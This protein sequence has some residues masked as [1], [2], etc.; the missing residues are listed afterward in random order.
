MSIKAS[1]PCQVRE[2]LPWDPDPP[3]SVREETPY[4]KLHKL[5]IRRESWQRGI[6]HICTRCNADW[7]LD[8]ASGFLLRIPAGCLDKARSWDAGMEKPAKVLAELLLNIGSVGFAAF[9]RRMKW[10]MFPCCVRDHAGVWHEKAFVILSASMPLPEWQK[11]ESALSDAAHVE[12]SRFA[13]PL[14]IRRE[15][16]NAMEIA[17]GF[18]PTSIRTSSGRCFNLWPNTDFMDKDGI[19]GSEC[20]LATDVDPFRLKLLT[21]SELGPRPWRRNV[22]RVDYPTFHGELTEDF[23]DLL[24]S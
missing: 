7:Y 5:I 1:C 4:F 8:H 11:G 13:L 14:D 10:L 6:L 2:S 16:Y 9:Q 20:S 23:E 18:N 21:S 19:I 3:A 17:M 22:R 12:Q 15:S 24:Y